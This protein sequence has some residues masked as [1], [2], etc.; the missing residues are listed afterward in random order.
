MD[1][2]RDRHWKRQTQTAIPSS[3]PVRDPNHIYQ[4]LQTDVADEHQVKPK[5]DQDSLRD[6]DILMIDSAGTEFDGTYGFWVNGLE[7]TPFKNGDGIIEI[8]I[9]SLSAVPNSPFPF[10]RLAGTSHE[11]GTKIL[12]YHQLNA[13]TFA[14][15]DWDSAVGG[16]VSDAFTIPM[17]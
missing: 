17:A 5:F 16:W 13:S 15:D 14:Q 12:L 4:L 11:N 2:T 10:A 7:L 3:T 9:P 8:G 6:S 1:H